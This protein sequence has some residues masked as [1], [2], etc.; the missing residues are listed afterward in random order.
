MDILGFF[1]LLW[2]SRKNQINS[3]ISCFEFAFYLH[4]CNICINKW[5]WINHHNCGQCQGTHGVVLCEVKNAEK[6]P[7]GHTG[8]A[9]V[10]PL[11]NWHRTPQWPRLSSPNNRN[12]YWCFCAT[13]HRLVRTLAF[14][15]QHSPT[16]HH[17][18]PDHPEFKQEIFSQFVTPWLL[19]IKSFL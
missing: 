12:K 2:E 3:H 18:L 5:K 15:I 8:T 10:G 9:K 13:R 4:T 14:T 6:P 7:K 19:Y 16:G 1:P 11:V 17:S